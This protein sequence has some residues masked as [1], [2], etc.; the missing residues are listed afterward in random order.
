MCTKKGLDCQHTSLAVTLKYGDRLE[1]G[2]TVEELTDHALST[3]MHSILI[4]VDE[5]SEVC[6]PLTITQPCMTF[7]TQKGVLLLYEG[8]RVSKSRIFKPIIMLH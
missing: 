3:F 7:Y 5:E 2:M 4:Y 1:G 8:T 6:Q